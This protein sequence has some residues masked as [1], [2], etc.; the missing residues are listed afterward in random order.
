MDGHWRQCC[1]H[2]C[3]DITLQ[4]LT[5]LRLISLDRLII[6]AAL[7]SDVLKQLHEG[8]H[9]LTRCRAD[10]RKSMWCP[11]ISSE[12][13]NIVSACIFCIEN[14]PA[15]RHESLLNTPGT[16]EWQCHTVHVRKISGLQSEVWVCVHNCYPLLPPGEWCCWASHADC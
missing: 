7:R 14:K 5:S 9:G 13:T 12:I 6:P 10:A 3:M 11:C 1:F 4:E 15:Q 16:A 8:H 2:L